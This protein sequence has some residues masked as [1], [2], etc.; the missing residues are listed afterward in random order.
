MTMG[1]RLWVVELIE[2]WHVFAGQTKEAIADQ[3]NDASQALLREVVNTCLADTTLD[4]EV[5]AS[6][7]EFAQCVLDLRKNEKAWSRA[8]GELLLKTYEQFDAGLADEAKESLRQ[9][10][11]DCPWRL[12]ADIADTQVHNFGG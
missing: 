6:A 3:F 7:D 2:R 10:R 12:F 1:D 4:G 9:F 8:L 5:F 11:G